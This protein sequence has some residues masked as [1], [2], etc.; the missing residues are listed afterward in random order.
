M[1]LT[2]RI[3]GS[4]PAR[5]RAPQ[6]V[7]RRPWRCKARGRRQSTRPP[8][9]FRNQSAVSMISFV[10]NDIFAAIHFDASPYL[11]PKAPGESCGFPFIVC[12]Q[13]SRDPQMR[14]YNARNSRRLSLGSRSALRF[15]FS[16]L[17][18]PSVRRGDRLGALFW[19]RGLGADRAGAALSFGFSPIFFFFFLFF[20]LRI[21]QWLRSRAFRGLCCRPSRRS[22]R[23]FSLAL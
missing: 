13:S 14:V 8:A 19:P 7:G 16:T 18:A 21:L 17:S 15:L 12:A 22:V 9:R 20:P 6:E 2:C 5:P 4:G 1:S 23:R 10:A 11:T 3:K